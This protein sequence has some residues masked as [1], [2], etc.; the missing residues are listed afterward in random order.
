MMVLD[1]GYEQFWSLQE[2]AVVQNKW[3]RKI[4]GQLANP[5]LCG[6]GVTMS[7]L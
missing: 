3:Y 6:N 4:Q 2:D 5:V 7:D 1:R